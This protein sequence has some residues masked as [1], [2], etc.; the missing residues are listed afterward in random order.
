[1]QVDVICNNS[2]R[3]SSVNCVVE[4]EKAVNYITPLLLTK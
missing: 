4:F 3:V 1:M 2:V